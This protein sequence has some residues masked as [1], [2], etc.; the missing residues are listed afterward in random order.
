M[1]TPLSQRPSFKTS[2][3]FK[4]SVFAAVASS[5]VRSTFDTAWTRV[6]IMLL[7]VSMLSPRIYPALVDRVMMN[8]TSPRVSNNTYSFRG[9]SGSM[10]DLLNWVLVGIWTTAVSFL[11]GS[12]QI[13]FISLNSENE[14][15]YGRDSLL[16]NS[17]FT[18]MLYQL[19]M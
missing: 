13:S 2:S 15:H 7:R 11:F 16:M 9:I 8:E 3:R 12:K 19:I 6:E 18:N 1:L 10:T 5:L 17:F 14:R 4:T